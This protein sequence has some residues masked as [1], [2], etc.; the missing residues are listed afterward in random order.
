MSDF[1]FPDRQKRTTVAG[2]TGSGKTQFSIGL[3][4][5]RDYGRRPWTI[6]DPKGDDL[7][8]EIDPQ[9]LRR[10]SKPPTDPGLYVIR[11]KFGDP[12]DMDWLE[13]YLTQIWVQ[14]NH[15]VHLDEGYMV[16]RNS[17]AFL[18]LLTQGRSKNIEMIMC[19]QRPVMC[20]PMMFSESDF[21]CSFRLNKPR[22]RETIN[23]YMNADVRN[24]LPEYN[25]YWYDVAKNKTFVLG[26][27]PSR[28]EI[29]GSFRH[30]LKRGIRTV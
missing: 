22:D 20:H 16:P 15:G 11:P 24:R 18:A 12:D 28:E 21:L 13:S 8:A 9:E 4:S 29:V 5:T 26:P 19:T 25:S 27:A 7:I 30:R 6:I 14:E 1:R 23:E 2:S 3:L 17:K 10:G